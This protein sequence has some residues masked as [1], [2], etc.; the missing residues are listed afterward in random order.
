MEPLRK[1]RQDCTVPSVMAKSNV[2]RHGQ[3]HVAQ[4]LLSPEEL[5]KHM[6]SNHEIECKSQLRALTSS[7]NG[8][9]ICLGAIGIKNAIVVECFTGLAAICVIKSEYEKAIKHYKHVLRWASD[10]TGTIR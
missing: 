10:Y 7:L 2:G 1:L 3:Q 5:H 9:T 4:R 8:K 6:V